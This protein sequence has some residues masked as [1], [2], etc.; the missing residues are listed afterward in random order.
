MNEVGVGKA[1]EEESEGVRKSEKK[2][3]GGGGE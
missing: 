1:R 2:I 3:Q